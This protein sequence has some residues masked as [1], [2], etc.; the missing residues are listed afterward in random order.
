MPNAVT[1]WDPE[2]VDDP[3]EYHN[4]F[5]AQGGVLIARQS[6]PP[7]E[8]F[9]DV[10]DLTEF[11][12]IEPAWTT[13]ADAERDILWWYEADPQVVSAS[14]VYVD[15]PA[16]RTL[17]IDLLDQDGYDCREHIYTDGETW[18]ELECAA[19]NAPGD[20][21]LSVAEAFEFLPATSE[22]GDT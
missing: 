9:C 8:N 5:L 4:A 20:R 1:W 3:S 10:Y 17:V 21:W 16:G 22:P 12:A 2:R 11:A 7:A 15:L 14:A 18:F 6:S 19:R 13:L